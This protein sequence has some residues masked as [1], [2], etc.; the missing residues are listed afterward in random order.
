MCI[1]FSIYH[2]YHRV[3]AEKST[4]QKKASFRTNKVRFQ[5]VSFF[6]YNEGLNAKFMPQDGMW[7]IV[8]ANCCPQFWHQIG[9]RNVEIEGDLMNFIN[10]MC[11]QKAQNWKIKL[12]S[13]A[14]LAI[15]K[16]TTHL[17]SPA[18]VQRSYYQ[19]NYANEMTKGKK[20]ANMLTVMAA[21][22]YPMVPPMLL[23]TYSLL[24]V[25]HHEE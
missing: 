25:T 2:N 24:L 7:R 19:D 6:T 3:R 9:L 10:S 17:Y 14:G 4:K 11:K 5:Y 20:V 21:T 16:L 18:H 1:P 15:Y 23:G 13:I 8:V 22:P 12:H